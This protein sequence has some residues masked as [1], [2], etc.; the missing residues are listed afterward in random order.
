MKEETWIDITTIEQY[1]QYQVEMEIFTNK[2]RYRK[3]QY[4]DLG[5]CDW[6]YGIPPKMK[7]KE[8]YD[9]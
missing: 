1:H 5:Y 6:I 9:R 2:F 3:Q 8:D 7:S 4:P